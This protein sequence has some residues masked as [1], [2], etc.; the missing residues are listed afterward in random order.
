M[1][2]L[3]AA[4]RPLHA[5]RAWCGARCHFSAYLIGLRRLARLDSAGRVVV[6]GAAPFTLSDA[7]RRRHTLLFSQGAVFAATSRPAGARRGGAANARHT[8]SGARSAARRAILA[9]RS[10]RHTAKFDD[11][12]TAGRRAR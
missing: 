7:G 12:D 8:S 10:R 1:P 6:F 11:C 5:F 4:C 9:M 2:S 3:G